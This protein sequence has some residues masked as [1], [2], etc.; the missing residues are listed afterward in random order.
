VDA[1]CLKRSTEYRNALV[2]ALRTGE[3]L[4]SNSVLD[5][6]Y[7]SFVSYRDFSVSLVISW[8]LFQNI[9]LTLPFMSLQ[10]YYA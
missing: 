6:D 8:I 4:G 9:S 1:L 10:A 5:F 2:L 7:I 3:V